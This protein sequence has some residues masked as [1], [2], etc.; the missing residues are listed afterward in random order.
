M[1]LGGALLAFYI[2]LIVL[3]VGI[4]GVFFG[5][6]IARVVTGKVSYSV[7][8]VLVGTGVF[9]TLQF[10]PYIGTLCALAL[11]LTVFGG[12]VMHIYRLVR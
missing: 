12:F 6:V 9:Y 8:W 4:A 2:G 11:V 5:G 10:I 7:L 1:L 3:A